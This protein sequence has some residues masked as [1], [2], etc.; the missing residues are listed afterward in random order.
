MAHVKHLI[1][2]IDPALVLK[3]K[4][5]PATCFSGRELTEGSVSNI[6]RRTSEQFRRLGNNF[7]LI[8]ES[9]IVPIK[10]CSQSPSL[11]ASVDVVMSLY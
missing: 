9:K 6:P 5:G 8:P 10:T 11:F 4:G 7:I 3:G 1:T 2:D